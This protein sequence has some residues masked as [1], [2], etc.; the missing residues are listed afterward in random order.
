MVQPSCSITDWYIGIQDWRMNILDG[1]NS[2]NKVVNVAAIE[3][4][5]VLPKLSSYLQKHAS[6]KK[7]HVLVCMHWIR[8]LIWSGSE[9]RD[10]DEPPVAGR[11]RGRDN[12]Y[13]DRVH[14]FQNEKASCYSPISKST[15]QWWR[16]CDAEWIL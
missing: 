14:G 7:D 16:S 6:V 9:L 3:I 13:N 4:S 5:N 8:Q 1:D 10:D 11:K 12:A 15:S 2:I